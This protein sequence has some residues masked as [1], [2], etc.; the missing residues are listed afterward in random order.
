MDIC[1]YNIAKINIVYSQIKI[2]GRNNQ[3]KKCFKYLAVL[4]SFVMVFSLSGFMALHT[5]KAVFAAESSEDGSKSPSA[6]DNSDDGSKSPSAGDNSDDGSKSPSAGDN[7]DDAPEIP[8]PEQP[9]GTAAG[10]S[11]FYSTESVLNETVGKDGYISNHTFTELIKSG[12]TLV[13]NVTDENGNVAATFTIDSS[14][15]NSIPD[16]V[17]R[18]NV[19][20]NS[21]AK[22]LQKAKESLK[23][24][25]DDMLLCTFDSVGYLNG[26]VNITVKADGFA[27]GTQLKLYY[28]NEELDTMMDKG[29]IVTVGEDGNVTFTVDHF[30]TYALVNVS[31]TLTSAPSTGFASSVPALIGVMVLSGGMAGTC[32]LKRRK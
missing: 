13:V 22:A 3:M 15:F 24:N 7:S 6:G 18:F 31:Q 5:A 12:K 17:F 29:Q 14:T 25:D 2:S 23:V 1:E 4:L 11:V 10:N 19:Q 21:Y 27:A 20:F 16:S 28:Y 30:S 8:A 26:K 32:F 9:S